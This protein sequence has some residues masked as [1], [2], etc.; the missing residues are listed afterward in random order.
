MP[1]LP[2]RKPVVTPDSTFA[3]TEPP[4]GLGLRMMLTTLLPS[5]RRSGVS[6]YSMRNTFLGFNER[7]LL[8]SHGFPLTLNTGVALSTCTVCNI[9]LTAKPG[10]LYCKALSKDNPFADCPNSFFVGMIM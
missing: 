10:I 5:Y 1:T 6:L 9:S 4:F 2:L 3:I 8:S 7:I